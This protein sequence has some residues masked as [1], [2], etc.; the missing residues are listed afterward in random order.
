MAPLRRTIVAC[1]AASIA[2]VAAARA[3]ADEPPKSLH[4]EYSS[5]E[6]ESIDD[7]LAER[8]AKI[9]VAPEGKI[10][11]AID[12]VSLEVI[13]KRD[14][15]PGFLNVFHTTSRPHVIEREVLLHVGDRYTQAL[16]DETARNLRDLIQLSLVVVLPIEGSAPDKVRI[17][18]ITKD[19][20]SFRLNSNVRFAGGKLEYLFL[21][22]SEWNVAGTHHTVGATFV[23]QPLSYSLG[24]TYAVPRVLGSRVA[25]DASANAIVNRRE[26]KAE[27]S[28][29]AASLGVPLWSAL[30]EWSYGVSGAWRNEITR[31]YVNGELGAFKSVAAPD[32]LVPFQYKSVVVTSA[33]YVTRSFGWSI[34]NDVTL[35]LE[36]SRRKYAVAFDSTQFD[37]RAVNEFVSRVLPLDDTRVNPFVQYRGYTSRFIR[38]LDFETLGLQE[39]YRLGHDVLFKFYPVSTALGSTRTFLGFAAGAQ[40]TFSIADGLSRTSIE[41]I[42]E[43]SSSEVADALI[44]GKER[45]VTPRMGLGRLVFDAHQLFRPRDSLNR[46]SFLGGDGRLRGYPT[47]FAFGKNVVAYNLEFRTRPIEILACELGLDA[48]FDTGDA[49][50]DWSKVHL[51]HAVGM[52]VRALF[53]QLDRLVF[54]TDVGFPIVKGGLPPGVHPYELVITFEQAFPMPELQPTSVFTVR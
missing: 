21:Q 37:P 34:K 27:G 32:S 25:F 41:S 19:V 18:V 10:V 26:G 14:P 28:Y 22:P 54:R 52:G 20:W 31:R 2:L 30:T 51:K 1:A 5:Y 47:N 29:G 16:V 46:I 38:V 7:A 8:K 23:L 42:V 3:G 35:G 39:D 40:Y 48:F 50:D 53:P 33:A 44:E 12:V 49:F 4:G 24:A 13:E 6:K 43:A 9:D 11:E 36:A 15:A 45:I 17:L